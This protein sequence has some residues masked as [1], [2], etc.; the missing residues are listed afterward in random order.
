MEKNSR[1]TPRLRGLS[2]AFSLM[3]TGLFGA[4]CQS[5]GDVSKQA[6]AKSNEASSAEQTATSPST[7]AAHLNSAAKASEKPQVANIEKWN[8]PAV[9]WSQAEPALS[10][11]KSSG[12]PGLV[13]VKGEWCPHCRKYAEI[14]SDP[15]VAELTKSFELILLENESDAVKLWQDTGTYVPRTLFLDPQGRLDSSFE[16]PNPRYPHFF[17]KKDKKKFVDAMS[18]ARQKYGS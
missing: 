5:K 12:R 1:L 17:S 15:A 18:R 9:S 13:V 2:L 10:R 16:G 6:K 14:F 3:A 4:G 7:S 11:M 8:Y